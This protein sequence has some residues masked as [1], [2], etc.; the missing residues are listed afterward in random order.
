MGSSILANA[1]SWKFTAQLCTSNLIN[2]L[3][4]TTIA[5]RKATGTYF[6]TECNDNVLLD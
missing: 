5:K 3:L 6:N 4:E 2:M 1:L